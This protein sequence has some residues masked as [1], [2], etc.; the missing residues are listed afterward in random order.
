MI[1]PLQFIADHYTEC[2]LA[3]FASVIPLMLLAQAYANSPAAVCQ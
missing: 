3:L 1:K 2:S